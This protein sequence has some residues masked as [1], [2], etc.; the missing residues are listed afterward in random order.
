MPNKDW[1]RRPA[2]PPGLARSLGLTPFQAHLL[3]NR[4]VTQRT[5]MDSYLA[6]D[7][8]LSHDPFLLPGMDDAVARLERALA[9]GETVGVFGDFDTDGISG[10]ALL[11]MALRELGAP[12]VPYLPHRVDEG[13]GLNAQAV[14]SLRSRGVSLM[15]TV[16]CGTSSAAEIEMASSIGMDTIV[17]DHHSLSTPFPPATALV[18]PKRP[19]SQYPYEGLT[20]AGLAYKLAE[21][22]WSALGRA[23]PHHLLELAALGTVADVGPLTGENRY[24]VKQGLDLLNRTQHPGLTALLEQARLKKG[25]LDTE[26]LSFGLIPRLNAAGRLGDAHTSLDLLVAE[27][28]EAA[29]PIAE[30]LEAQNRERQQLT[31]ESMEQAREQVESQHDAPPHI[32]VVEHRDWLPGVLGLIAGGLSEHYYRPAIAVRTDAQLSRGSARSIPEFDMIEA[33]RASGAPFQRFGG[34]PRAAGFTLPTPDLPG[35]KARLPALAADKLAS[36]DLTPSI[37]VD[38]EI[39]PLLMDGAN[40]GFIQSLGPFGEGNPAPVFL[41]R[42]ARVLAARQVGSDSAHLKMRVGHSGGRW[43]AIAF[44]RGADI[45]EPGAMVDLVYTMQKN[46]WDGQERLELKVL[47][48]R[49]R[50]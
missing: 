35:L 23:K 44:R 4:G 12:V 25:E 28:L 17:T 38:C 42:N 18:N 37:E 36:V 1:R 2:P 20:G 16:D 8:R 40:F 47:D 41:T 27:S 7:E 46:N 48:F 22:L 11:V 50:A 26:S 13:H 15:V 29:R 14:E 39:S 49:V 24:M 5:Q 31:H 32:I 34:H 43:D 9:A 45:C 3:F 21:A 33:L 6:A 30:G 10:T 19:D